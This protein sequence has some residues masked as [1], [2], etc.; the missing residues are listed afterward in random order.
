M[1]VPQHAKL[2]LGIFCAMALTPVLRGEDVHL[3]SGVT[4]RNVTVIRATAT[5]IVFR[6]A[7]DAPN[8]TRSLAFDA[9]SQ[10]DRARFGDKSA[11]PATA[12]QPPPQP[13]ASAPAAASSARTSVSLKVT[14]TASKA[15][16]SDNNRYLFGYDR[17]VSRSRSLS[18]RVSN[19]GAEPED[20][21]IE[22]FFIAKPA[23]GSSLYVHDTKKIHLNLKPSQWQ[24]V[25]AQAKELN[26]REINDDIGFRAISGAKIQGW[27]VRVKKGDKIVAME[28]SSETLK[29]VEPEKLDKPPKNVNIN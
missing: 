21:D 13:V 2:A 3:T 27:I 10:A 6:M 15:N 14:E 11:Q 22:Y 18:V 20:V 8:S 4:F 5:G 7:G 1:R 9:M 24:D 26:S 17:T 16:T 25:P 12:A 28:A 19:L 23:H 29:S